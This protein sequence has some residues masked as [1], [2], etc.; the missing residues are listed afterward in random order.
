MALLLGWLSQLIVYVLV[1]A[2]FLSF[3]FWEM[4]EER[5]HRKLEAWVSRKLG[6]V[7]VSAEVA[8]LRFKGIEL[9]NVQI[10]NSPG[11][12]AAPYFL[13]LRVLRVRV[14]GVFQLVTLPG[15]VPFGG[16]LFALGFCT[17]SI[18]TI[19]VEGLDVR[20]EHKKLDDDKTLSNCA[21]VATV[22]A[23]LKE[24]KAK[25]LN[26]VRQ[27]V[28]AFRQK[29]GAE[30]EQEGENKQEDADDDD[31]QEE[32]SFDEIG[33]TFMSSIDSSYGERRQVLKDAIMNHIDKLKGKSSYSLS[34]DIQRRLKAAAT[35]QIGLI[36]CKDWYADIN[37][38]HLTL[39]EEGWEL[40]GFVGSSADLAKA[41]SVGLLPRVLKENLTQKREQVKESISKLKDDV[42]QRAVDLRQNVTDKLEERKNAIT[43]KVIERF[44][45]R[46]EKAEERRAAVRARIGGV[47][48]RFKTGD[49]QQ[50]PP[51]VA[52]QSQTGSDFGIDEVDD[53]S[54][55]LTLR[56]EVRDAL[57]A[58]AETT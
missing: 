45:Q 37:G 33:K 38:R 21:F 3:A 49:D 31:I 27:R 20:V 44:E 28:K 35:N 23:E 22:Q 18:E 54:D 51:M 39:G 7:A 5:L 40:R 1:I 17:R 16:G 43:G 42:K 9:R 58:S 8:R 26:K 41:V 48:Q 14:A 12:F 50:L 52:A 6:G 29:W 2:V 55:D 32:V 30:N 47:F 53:A 13:R 25:R 15:I 36:T 56:A 19:E 10:G 57:I 11:E 24:T 34:H 46:R 4:I